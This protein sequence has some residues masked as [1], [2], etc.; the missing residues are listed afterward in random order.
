MR[1]TVYSDPGHAWGK[2][3]LSK[4]A[5]L[6]LIDRISSCSFLRGKFAYLEEDCDLSLFI[7]AMRDRG[8]DVSF[9]E[10]NRRSGD[11]VIRSY[12]HYSPTKAQA[13][14]DRP[15]LAPGMLVKFPHKSSTFELIESIGRRGW[16]VRIPG[17]SFVYRATS[18]HIANCEVLWR[19]D[20][21]ISLH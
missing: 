8:Q 20:H 11:S 14:L 12:D 5:Q 10:Q 4:L 19:P 2:V 6:D 7:L 1:I 18:A 15:T 16:I 21:A 17:Q 9:N 13:L 3:S